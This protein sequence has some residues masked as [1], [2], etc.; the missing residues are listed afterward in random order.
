[1]KN[2]FVSVN[3]G[4]VARRGVGKSLGKAAIVSMYLLGFDAAKHPPNAGVKARHRR[5]DYD[6]PF[7]LHTGSGER[8]RVSCAS[9]PDILEAKPVPNIVL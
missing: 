7:A 8:F 6:E 4:C 5:R 3:F 1:M 2:G 9:I